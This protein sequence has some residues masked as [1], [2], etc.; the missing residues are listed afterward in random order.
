M[1]RPMINDPAVRGYVDIEELPGERNGDTTFADR[2]IRV[3]RGL[4]P[5]QAV[6][7][8]V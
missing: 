4:A 7:I 5:A 2:R 8:G 3:R 6:G 1:L